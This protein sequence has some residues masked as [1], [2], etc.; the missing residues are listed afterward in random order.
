MTQH[1]EEE[2]TPVTA[3]RVRPTNLEQLEALVDK[4][5]RTLYGDERG[6]GLVQ[7]VDEQRGAFVDLQ[8]M[9]FEDRERVIRW[10]EHEYPRLRA[11]FIVGTV[12]SALCAGAALTVAF[13]VF[14][15]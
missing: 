4:H 13:R 2:R 15:Q 9:Y 6:C 12:S 5:D 7:E 8:A 14:L 10:V 1:E 11:L 3:Q